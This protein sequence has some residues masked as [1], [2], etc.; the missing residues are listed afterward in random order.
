MPA[1][2]RKRPR[3]ALGQ[4]R[5]AEGVGGPATLNT[6]RCPQP[7]GLICKSGSRPDAKSFVPVQ[8][9]A[10]LSRTW[11]GVTRSSVGHSIER[12]SCSI[13]LVAHARQIIAGINVSCPTEEELLKRFE[14]TRT[15]RINDAAEGNLHKKPLCS[16]DAYQLEV[17]GEYPCPIGNE[18]ILRDA[19][20]RIT[21][22]DHFGYIAMR[23]SDA[24]WKLLYLC[25]EEG[26]SRGLS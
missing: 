8:S 24:A 9:S 22:S 6:T 25:G 15:Q 20:V 19:Y 21:T 1:S 14:R 4:L 10:L 16:R 5:G 11:V 23:N 18:V 13:L 26:V 2:M 7:T 3:L 17:I 12:Q